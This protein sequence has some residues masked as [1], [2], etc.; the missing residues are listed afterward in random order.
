M[1]SEPPRARR[2]RDALVAC[3]L[4]LVAAACFAV[5]VALPAQAP[6]GEQLLALEQSGRAQPQRAA[7]QLEAL[8]AQTAPDSA[9]RLELL[10]LQGLA[11]ADAS[12]ANGV[13]RVAAAL[14][15][16]AGERNEPLAFATA[17]LA[18]A[19]LTTVTGNLAR[20]DRLI[21]E[22]M[23]R[24]PADAEPRMRLR[25]LLVQAAVKDRSGKLE[26]AVRLWH[27]ALSLADRL[28]L[29][30][31]QAEVRSALAY[32]YFQA[33]QLDAA[34]RLN[35]EA[36]ALATLADDGFAQAGAWNT[37]GI[38]LDAVGDIEGERR[39][40]Q[41]AILWARR[42]GAKE[43]ESLYMANLADFYLKRGEYATALKLSQEALPLVRELN[44]LSG[45]TVAL[46]NMG[47]AYI[48]LKQFDAGRRYLAQSIAID[49]RRGSNTGV[50]QTLE[51]MGKYLEKAGDAHG[52]LEAYQRFR[53][54]SD[55]ILQRDQQKAIV[56]MQEQFDNERR[57][58]EL[59]LL[60]R[61]NALKTEQ[62]HR[63]ELLQRAWVL[64]AAI[65]LLSAA[66]VA[67]LVRR[68]RGANRRLA[69]SN[70]QL[71][72]FS[73]RDPLTGLANR[74]HF[75]DV[76]RQHDGQLAGTVFLV[77]I[78]HFKRINDLH[79]HAVGDAVL[80]EVAERLRQVLR[81]PDLIVRWGGEEFLIVVRA[82]GPD[83]VEALA[84]RLL[85]A[86]GGAPVASGE[87]GVAVSAS[88]GFATF[89]IE[90][91]LLTVSWE[92][93]IDLVDTAMYLAKAHGRNRA[94][95]VRL[96]LAEHESALQTITRALEEAWREGKVALT[97]LQGPTAT[98][99]ERVAM[100][101]L[102]REAAA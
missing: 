82:L 86:V 24:L 71:K 18:R 14:E 67:L 99:S 23:L 36:L 57:T 13:E 22:A 27:E 51:E 100:F 1:L 9:E 49:E 55:E 95:G 42:A 87:H 11:F 28:A 33:G 50:A 74:R 72:G 44:S 98:P 60:E 39:S 46:A 21:A 96:L 90:P 62:L 88:I 4:S 26:D 68:V 52:A 83:Q 85:D 70:E 91:H 2:L 59:E 10:T 12:D 79:G 19:E 32:S 45:Q 43:R 69:S 64:L 80:V 84:Q 58:R 65:G 63:R 75:Q 41:S 89:P 29:P 37:Q 81:A 54:L 101:P 6:I 30:W 40:F 15:A 73:E 31:R 3:A 8:L 53:R 94:Y 56:E 92:A 35:D 16:R 17:N 48:S 5:N 20:A 102:R 47:L 7:A 93:A 34:R 61:D 97:L 38:L 66:L 78:D 25:F 77:D 76:M